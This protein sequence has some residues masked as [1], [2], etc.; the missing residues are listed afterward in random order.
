MRSVRRATLAYAAKDTT[1]S[2]PAT[3]MVAWLP[4]IVIDRYRQNLRPNAGR[5][6]NPVSGDAPDWLLEPDLAEV[7]R[8]HQHFQDWP[9]VWT[10]RIGATPGGQA[11]A[12]R[13]HIIR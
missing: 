2:P 12:V 6:T 10:A 4:T 11:N 5:G 8:H 7:D 9:A 13:R 3:G 1:M